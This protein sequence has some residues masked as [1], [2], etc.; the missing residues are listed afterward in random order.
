MAKTDKNLYLNKKKLVKSNYKKHNTIKHFLSYYFDF[1]QLTLN[2]NKL[3]KYSKDIID[4]YI[5]SNST[6]F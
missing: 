5:R 3:K 4:K 1:I 6:K 2:Q